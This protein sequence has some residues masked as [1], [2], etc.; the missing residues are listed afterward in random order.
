VHR[1]RPRVLDD[2]GV[3]RIAHH[4]VAQRRQELVGE[5]A[6]L[7]AQLRPVG[8]GVERGGG[9]LEDRG[10]HEMHGRDEARVRAQRVDVARDQPNLVAELLEHHLPFG[11]LE[12]D[13]VDARQAGSRDS[14]PHGVN[15]F[16]VGG[17]DNVRRD[18]RV[19]PRRVSPRRAARRLQVFGSPEQL[20]GAGRYTSPPLTSL[21]PV[22]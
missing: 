6:D 16:P 21:L 19:W 5:A 22:I 17:A 7:A 2:Q 13:P 4:P 15:P 9:D 20:A 3:E 11:G 12:G 18:Y 8:C 1:N 10:V 14:D